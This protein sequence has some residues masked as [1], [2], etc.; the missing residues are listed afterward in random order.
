M[1]NIRKVKNCLG[2]SP[3][4]LENTMLVFSRSD[5]GKF[6]QRIRQQ[7]ELRLGVIG[8]GGWGAKS[9]QGS[10]LEKLIFKKIYILLILVQ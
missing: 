5:T 6:A 2:W 8:V 10:I 3:T 1:E 9:S 4:T 7:A